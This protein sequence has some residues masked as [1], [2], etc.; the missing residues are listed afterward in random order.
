MVFQRY[1]GWAVPHLRWLRSP[2]GQNYFGRKIATMHTHTP[3][4]YRTTGRHHA[5]LLLNCSRGVTHACAA[6]LLRH[7]DPSSTYGVPYR[8]TVYI[9]PT[10]FPSSSIG[11]DAARRV[12]SPVAF[13]YR[14]AFSGSGAPRIS[15]D[16]PHF[17]E[18]YNSTKT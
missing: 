15:C 5:L 3:G 16:A 7:L 11:A 8:P 18:L 6:V 9:L 10:S 12:V 13:S 14:D 1:N 4:I 17:E 2:G